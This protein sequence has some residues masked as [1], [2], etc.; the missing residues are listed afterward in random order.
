[1]KE[2]FPQFLELIQYQSMYVGVFLWPILL[3]ISYIISWALSLPVIFSFQKWLIHL[4]LENGDKKGL[5]PILKRIK[6]PIRLFMALVLYVMFAESEW[7]AA[8]SSRGGSASIFEA[9]LIGASVW[10]IFQIF[11]LISTLIEKSIIENSDDEQHIR[12]VRTRYMLARR[13]FGVAFAVIGV[14]LVLVQ[15][16]AVKEIG[17]SL[18]TSAGIAG[19]VIG[20]AAQKSIAS[21]VAG[22]QMALTQPIKIGDAVIVEK[23]WGWIEEIHLTYVVVRIWD[24]RRLI[25]P[26]EKFLNA[27]FQNWTRQSTELLGPVE[28]YADYRVPVELLRERLNEIVKKSDLWNEKVCGLQVTDVSESTIKLRALVSADTAPAAWDLRCYVREE[29]IAFLGNLDGGKYLPRT[30]WEE[31]DKDI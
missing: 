28:F 12:S 17:L 10:L 15:F 7:L 25:V 14:A 11:N 29:L 8:S 27:S 31:S 5:S 18:L 30:R 1:M 2:F 22:L 6:R 21:I 3:L 23:E 16:E 20:F 26:I 13:V 19:I 24:L 4:I 9:I